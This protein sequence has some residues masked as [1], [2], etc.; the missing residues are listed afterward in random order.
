LTS[1]SA[2][3]EIQAR[4][5]ARCRYAAAAEP[6][7][8]YALIEVHRRSAILLRGVYWLF[9]T[10]GDEPLDAVGAAVP[11]TRAKASIPIFQFPFSRLLFIN[12]TVL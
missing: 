8:I 7:T 4:D 9:G 6:D 3:Q 12:Q 1:G 11:A 5:L 10:A 2:S